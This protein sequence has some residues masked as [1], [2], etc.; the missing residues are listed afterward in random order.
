MD[1]KRLIIEISPEEHK[2]LKHKAVELGTSMKGLVFEAFRLMELNACATSRHIPNEKTKQA[3]KNA[4]E[5]KNLIRGKKAINVLEK[6][7][8]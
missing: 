1:T 7:G 5:E 2:R 3:M 6:L 8:L 4:A